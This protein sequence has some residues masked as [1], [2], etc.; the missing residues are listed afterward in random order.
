[1]CVPEE[2]RERDR[3]TDREREIEL[4]C[5]SFFFVVWALFIFMFAHGLST[6]I[7]NLMKPFHL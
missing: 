5:V 7:C 1:M 3:E 2:M 4:L 6:S